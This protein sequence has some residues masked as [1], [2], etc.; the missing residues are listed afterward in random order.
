MGT[1]NKLL[2]GPLQT[3]WT[4][5]RKGLSLTPGRGQD[6][7]ICEVLQGIAAQVCMNVY[8]N[9]DVVIHLERKRKDL[10]CSMSSV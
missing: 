10:K 4:Q 9:Y 1:N 2:G 3:R 8:R 6:G 5:D 7:H